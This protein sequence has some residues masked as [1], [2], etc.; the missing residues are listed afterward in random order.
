MQAIQSPLAN[1]F[2]I[3][4]STSNCHPRRRLRFPAEPQN[5][6]LE[7]Q[8]LERDPPSLVRTIGQLPNMKSREI[9]L[10]KLKLRLMD[11][12]FANH[13]APCT[14]IWLQPLQSVLAL[15]GCSATDLFLF[16]YTKTITRFF[17]KALDVYIQI[18]FPEVS[19]N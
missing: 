15:R 10:R 18:L 11:K 1:L 8:V 16:V 12:R 3:V 2:G 17:Y 4:V 7:V 6:F 9:R 14:A 13:K 5:F 19:G